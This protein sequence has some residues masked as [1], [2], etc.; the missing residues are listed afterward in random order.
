M[1]ILGIDPGAA[2]TG[3]GLIEVEAQRTRYVDACVIRP[4]A[5]RS[6]AA[7]VHFIYQH[8]SRYLTEQAPD[9]IAVES[10]FHAR[11]PRTAIVLGH[12]R[13]VI[14]LAAAQYGVEVTDYAPREIKQS[15]TG[16]GAASK[17]QVGQMIQQLLGAPDGLAHD[18]A[19]A[20]AVALCHFH[21]TSGSL[22]SG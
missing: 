21:R 14:L 6:L 7:R 10:L 20:L 9:Q 18:A 17:E 2:A 4:P 15:V 13:G 11:S 19:D 22:T 12:A 16:R 5:G 1:R 8:V 3:C